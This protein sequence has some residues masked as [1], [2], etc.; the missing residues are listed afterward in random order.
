MGKLAFL[1]EKAH[2]REPL[3]MSTTTHDQ[4]T[5]LTETHI[6]TSRKNIQSWLR[7][8]LVFVA[9]VASLTIEMAASRLLAPYFGS[10]LFVWAN[11]IGLILLYLTIGYYVGGLLADRQPYPR[12]FYGITALAALLIGIVPLIAH[13]ILT[14]ALNTFAVYPLGIFYGSLVSIILLFALPTLLLGCIS[15]YAIRL[16]VEQVGRTGRTAGMLYAISTA[17][18]IIGTFVPVLILLPDIGTNLTFITCAAL[19]F[20]VSIVALIITESLSH[21][22]ASNKRD[23]VRL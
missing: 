20:F 9:G 2:E 22:R 14:W 10:S 13:P 16:S 7:I 23:R 11:L 15:P 21:Y 18:S 1:Q 6:T 8:I 4:D 17:G 5:T 19:L 12:L 3:H